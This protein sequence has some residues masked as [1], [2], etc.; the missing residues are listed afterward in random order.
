MKQ[1]L[2]MTAAPAIALFALGFL[3]ISASTTPASAGEYCRK[4]VTSAITSC[5]FDTME[6]CLAM[7]SG[8]G[9]DCA[10]DPFLSD[11]KNAL[12][13]FRQTRALSISKIR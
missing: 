6:Q 9:G 11:N 10:R 7:R 5:S 3:A 12:A 13:P 8:I 2:T 1:L 4:D